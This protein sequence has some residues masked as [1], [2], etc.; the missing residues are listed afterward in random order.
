M[1]GLVDTELGDDVAQQAD[2]AVGGQLEAGDVEDLRADVAVQADQAQVVGREHPPHR[3]HRR[4]A[5][6]RQTELL[7][8]VRG[9]DELVGVGLDA[10]GDANQNVLHDAGGTGDRVE[11]LDLG[12]RVEHDVTDAGLDGHGQLVDGLVV[13][14][15][16]DSLGRE[17]G[18]QRDGELAAA[19]DV[20]RQ[21]LFVDP[22]RDLGAQ[23]RLC[24]VADVLA[25]AER[26]GDVA[27]AGPEVVLVDDEQ[28]GAVLGG[29]LGDGHAGDRDLAVV[30]ANG[31]AR[32]HV[33][34]EREHVGRGLRPGRGAAVVDLLGVAGTGGMSDHMRS[35]AVTPRISR[36]L[37]ITW[38]VAW[39]SASRAACSSFGA[40]SP[41]GSTRQE[42]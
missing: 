35:G 9:G 26:R 24:G 22:A 23:E 21:A 2:H 41:C 33:R 27:A 14:V 32:P 25:A 4:A 28:R 42:S 6:Q 31:V 12:H 18:V 17:A 11:S 36:P 8:L 20:E 30:A 39:H 1:R 3:V 5:G 37:A 38:R 40:S 34:C 16:R 13:A 10:D 29:E 7:V 19:A 15:Q